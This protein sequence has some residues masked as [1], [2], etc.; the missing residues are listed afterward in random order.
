[1]S[2]R[3]KMSAVE[4]PWGGLANTTQ[5]GGAAEGAR[6]FPP[7]LG[8]GRSHPNAIGHVRPQFRPQLHQL[9]RLKPQFPHSVESAEGGRRIAASPAS[10]AA[11]GIFLWIKM[12]TPC[13]IPNRSRSREAARKARFRSS[14]EP[15]PR[16][17]PCESVRHPSPPDRSG[18]PDRWRSSPFPVHDSRLPVYVIRP[19]SG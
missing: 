11:T 9:L 16:C 5:Q 3:R 15:A 6:G 12:R 10:P 1:M 18:R 4:T 8:Q 17:C 13:R 2:N 7:P 14:R 19:K